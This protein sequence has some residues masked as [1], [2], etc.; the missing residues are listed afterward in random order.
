MNRRERM[1][2]R[3]R[4]EFS[5]EVLEIIDDSESHR[6]HSGY[7][8]GGETHYSIR[9]RA[10]AFNGLGRIACQRRI[11]AALKHE[12]ESGLH[13]LSLDVRGTDSR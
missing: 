7:R 8:R 6:G 2:E 1:S 10:E 4:K 12:F 3:I 9:L 13:A 11:H 5:P